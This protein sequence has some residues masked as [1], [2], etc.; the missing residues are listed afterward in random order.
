ELEL[1][2]WYSDADAAAI[3][4]SPH[5]KHLQLLELWL[6][7]RDHLT[8]SWLCQ[9]M[10][11]SKAWPHLRELTLL[12]PDGEN[13]GSRKQ[14]AGLVNEAAGGRGGVSRRGS[15]ELFPFAVYHRYIFPGY[16]P[17]GRMAMA[18]QDHSTRPPSLCVLTFDNKGNQTGDVLTVPMPAE[19]LAGQDRP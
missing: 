2:C 15:P 17:D 7:R 18:C 1:A 6:G 16:L 5:L 11:G 10:G 3:A 19:I 12:N 14:L 8:D 4:A 13:E 9:V